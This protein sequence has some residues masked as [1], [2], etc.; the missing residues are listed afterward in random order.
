MRAGLRQ[1]LFIWPPE[2][3]ETLGRSLVPAHN[4][5]GRCSRVAAGFGPCRF[6]VNANVDA[7]RLTK[8]DG[9]FTSR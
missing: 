5:E 8:V 9:T 7:E 2:G 3:P 4:H 1:R 6:S